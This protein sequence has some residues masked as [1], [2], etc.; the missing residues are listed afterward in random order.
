M[1]KAIQELTYH[2]RDGKVEKMG[3]NKSEHPTWKGKGNHKSIELRRKSS[4]GSMG[5]KTRPLGEVLTRRASK[6]RIKPS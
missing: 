6:R 2:Y 4:Y 5:R 1:K 3:K